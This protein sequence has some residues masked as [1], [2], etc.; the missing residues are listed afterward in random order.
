MDDGTYNYHLIASADEK[1]PV[2]SALDNG[3][4][5]RTAFV[6]K[7]VAT[8]GQFQVKDRNDREVRSERA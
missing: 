3:R 8:G 2:R 5:D 4:A 6:L 1:V 7:S